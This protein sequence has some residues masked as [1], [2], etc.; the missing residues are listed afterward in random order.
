MKKTIASNFYHFD[1]ILINV[2]NGRYEHIGLN[3]MAA[4][5][6]KHFIEINFEIQNEFFPQM[7]HLQ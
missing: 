2:F 7:S 4:I 5:W 1:I 3:K 6:S